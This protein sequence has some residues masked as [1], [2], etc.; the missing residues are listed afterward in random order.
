MISTTFSLSERFII[1][2]ILT[3]S[4]PL[5]PSAS[6]QSLTEEVLQF[7]ESEVVTRITA[8]AFSLFA[9]LDMTIHLGNA[10]YLTLIDR[11]TCERFEQGKI[12]KHLIRAAYFLFQTMVGAVLGTLLPTT[13]K[14]FLCTPNAPQ[15]N[16]PNFSNAPSK[17]RELAN[18]YQTDTSASLEDAKAF[19]KEASLEEREAFIRVFSVDNFRGFQRVRTGLADTVY[20]SLISTHQVEWLSPNDRRLSLVWNQS[21]YYYHTSMESLEEIFKSKKIEVKYEKDFHGAFVFTAP[22]QGFGR[23]VLALRRNIERL[24]ELAHG[25]TNYGGTY[26]A[27]FSRSIPVT[28]ETLAYICLDGL[29]MREAWQVNQMSLKWRGKQSLVSTIPNLREAFMAIDNLHL[30]IPSEWPNILQFNAAAA[31]SSGP[32]PHDFTIL[33]RL[34]ERFAAEY[35]PETDQA[36]RN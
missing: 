17:I 19:W 30:G 11:C 22:Q 9:L 33:R 12:T 28:D 31:A 4:A 1:E 8:L 2:P 32:T 15:N 23:C 35:S 5:P 16:A 34:Q 18:Q 13:L 6:E 27:G 7:I 21:F 3:W 29:G 24:S 20:K 14:Y 36:D 10:L 26:V 25:F